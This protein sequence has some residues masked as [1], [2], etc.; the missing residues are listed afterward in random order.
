MQAYRAALYRFRYGRD[1]D[2][3]DRARQIS[4]QAYGFTVSDAIPQQMPHVAR[5]VAILVL[6]LV[7][8]LGVS[9]LVWE[10]KAGPLVE[11]IQGTKG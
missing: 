10:W 8:M 2:P 11:D 3:A 6:A 7:G 1:P 5:W 4:P 9:Q